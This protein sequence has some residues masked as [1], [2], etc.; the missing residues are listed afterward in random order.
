MD[1]SDAEGFKQLIFHAGC[2]GACIL[3][4]SWCIE[5]ECYPLLIPAYIVFAITSSF[6]FNGFHEMVHN[7]AFRTRAFNTG[8]AHIIGFFIF[9]GATWFWCFH[10]QHHRYTNDVTP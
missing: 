4:V 2:A 9:R 7:T 3:A 6:I 1:P 5:H 10:W 8:F